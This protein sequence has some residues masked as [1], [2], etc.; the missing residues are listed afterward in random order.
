VLLWPQ[1][2]N[3]LDGYVRLHV[4][5][6]DTN[7]W[8]QDVPVTQ[9]RRL[10]VRGNSAVFDPIQNALL[11]IGGLKGGDVDP[12]IQHFFLYRYGNASPGSR[13]GVERP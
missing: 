3:A 11:L 8:E 12:A 13:A 7:T 2:P 9:P 1:L 10:T 5:H 4:Y 6:P